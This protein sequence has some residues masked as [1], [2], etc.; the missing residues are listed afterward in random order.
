M[1]FFANSKVC[2]FFGCFSH[3]RSPQKQF[4]PLN[5][6]SRKKKL[7]QESS[8]QVSTDLLVWHEHVATVTLQKG[9]LSRRQFSLNN[10]CKLTLVCLPYLPCKMLVLG[11]PKW[12]HCL[13]SPFLLPLLHQFSKIYSN[14]CSECPAIQQSSY[15]YTLLTYDP[16]NVA[17][18]AC[19]SWEV[20]GMCR[21]HK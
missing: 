11:P 17:C 5:Y 16:K 21:Q 4:P 9:V 6:I 3:F 2:L 12:I 18:C 20:Y 8:V 19:F 15:Y 13:S 10:F 7:G 14:T 1:S